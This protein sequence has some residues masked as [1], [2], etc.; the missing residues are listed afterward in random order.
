VIDIDSPAPCCANTEA[1]SP[2][3]FHTRCQCRAIDDRWNWQRGP[4]RDVIRD[5]RKTK[6]WW[7]GSQNDL[8]D[9]EVTRAVE[10]HLD[11]INRGCGLNRQK[12][13]EFVNFMMNA[14]HRH[15]FSSK[16]LH[17]SVKCSIGQSPVS[18]G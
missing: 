1:T 9:A 7:L 8:D 10:D 12:R 14:G 18:L 6:L 16:T 3:A 17:L 4:G 11:Y 15:G 13:A 2:S 5:E